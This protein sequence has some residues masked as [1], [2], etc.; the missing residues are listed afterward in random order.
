MTGEMNATAALVLNNI[1][2]SLVRHDCHELAIATFCDSLSVLRCMNSIENIEQMLNKANHCLACWKDFSR[3]QTRPQDA[4]QPYLRICRRDIPD[5]SLVAILRREFEE[6]II[7]EATSFHLILLHFVET[8]TT[9][10]DNASLIAGVFESTILNNLASAIMCAW[11]Q[12]PNDL[13]LADKA[14]DVWGQSA[15]ILEKMLCDG[16][17]DD[18][19]RSKIAALHV[20]VLR[21]I[22]RTATILGLDAVAAEAH[23]Q[24]L[25]E[26]C[27]FCEIDGE[28]YAVDTTTGFAAASAA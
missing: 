17:C 3:L 9:C 19:L 10:S 21:C 5:D 7:E 24:T 8:P 28:G 13:R 23:N 15:G 22:E 25:S 20:C 26:Y 18:S 4:L 12:Q 27:Y 1:G 11:G 14:L 6:N 2:L 16:V